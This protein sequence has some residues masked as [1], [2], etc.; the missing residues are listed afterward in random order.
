MSDRRRYRL[1]DCNPQWVEEHRDAG[2][3]GK[4]HYLRFECPEGHIGC[5]H[6]IPFTPRLNGEAFV[7]RQMPTWQRSGDTFETFSLSPTIRR[8]QHY[9]S[10]EAALAAGVKPEYFEESLTCA[11]HI[12]VRDGAIQFCGDSK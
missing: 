11:L 4:V 3:E 7:D 9:S 10:R 1:V 5:V 6:V 8:V 2:D 12:F